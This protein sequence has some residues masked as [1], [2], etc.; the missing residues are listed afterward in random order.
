MNKTFSFIIPVYNGAG[1]IECALDS[2][3]SQGLQLEDFEVICVDDCSSTEETF[4]TLIN[5]KYNGVHPSN[6]IVLRHTVNKRQGGARN[7]GLK[8]AQGKWVLYLDADDYFVAKSLPILKQ[9]L[10][11]NITDCVMFDCKNFYPTLGMVD[12]VYARRKILTNI[13]MGGGEFMQKVPIPW[14]PWLY[15]Y[16]KDFLVSNKILFTENVRF[17][18]TDYVI[19]CTLLATKILFIPLDVVVHKINEGSTSMV[20]NDVDKITDL[21]RLSYRIRSL[22]DFF[23]QKDRGGGVAAMGHH[24]FHY[25]TL[26]VSYLWRLSYDEIVEILIKYPPYE[27][28]N[29]HLIIFVSK[30]PRIYAMTA[31][32]MRPVLLS[33]LWIRKRMRR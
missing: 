24:V 3:Y 15:A 32:I 25:H 5:Y 27:N 23:L 20:G 12:A 9:N 14:V 21:F 28:S 11:K 7:T 10:T 22:A 8:H 2:I 16:K 4:N 26:L 33:L 29:D 17:E 1:V 6:L 18:D 30:F 13:I 19:K 31:Q